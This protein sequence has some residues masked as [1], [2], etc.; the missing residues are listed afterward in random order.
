M[1]VGRHDI[2]KAVQVDIGEQRAEGGEPHAGTGDPRLLGLIQKV[3][4]PGAAGRSC[5]GGSRGT[6]E[7]QP[8]GG[9]GSDQQRFTAVVPIVGR[10][11]PHAGPRLP[12]DGVSDA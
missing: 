3:R 8:F 11:D 5:G 2:R 6:I 7:T 9:V 4:L 12:I 1:A 10:I